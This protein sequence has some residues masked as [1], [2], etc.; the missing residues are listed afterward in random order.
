VKVG[1]HGADMSKP[2]D[3]EAMMKYAAAEFGRV[4][5]LVNNAGIQ[6]VAKVEDFPPERWDA[7]SPSTSRAPST[8][9]ASRCPR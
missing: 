8:P 7:S 3:I 4:D 6:H 2:A 1:Y 9:R 5:I